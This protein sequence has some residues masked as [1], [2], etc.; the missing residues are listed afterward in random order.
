METISIKISGYL[1][2]DSWL[3]QIECW[4]PL[5]YDITREDARCD[6]PAG[7][8][9]HVCAATND[10]DFQGADIADGFVTITREGARDG[11]KVKRSRDFP[12]TMFPSVSDMVRADWDG[13]CCDDFD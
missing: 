2:G 3:P 12:L 13:P 1:V 10:G 8:R 4:K 9:W 7:L 5:S 11:I 6:G